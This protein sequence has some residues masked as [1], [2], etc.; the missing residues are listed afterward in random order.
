MATHSH[1]GG[2][3]KGRVPTSAAERNRIASRGKATQVGVIMR[4]L[5]VHEQHLDGMSPADI[6]KQDGRSTAVIRQVIRRHQGISPDS[7]LALAPVKIVEKML[8]RSETAWRMAAAIAAGTE[9]DA[10]RVTAIRTMLDA[11][12]R[13]LEI[14]QSTGH[15]PRELGT[16]RHLV[17]VRHIAVSMIDAVRALENGTRTPAEVREVFEGLLA[18]TDGEQPVIDVAP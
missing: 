4:D 10:T 3:G 8:R 2:A 5:L 16:L 12:E 11:D 7:L 1:G 15:L 14:L 17:D 6:A 9:Q 18:L 13:V